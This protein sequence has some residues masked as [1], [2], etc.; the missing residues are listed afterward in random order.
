MGRKFL[1]IFII[2]FLILLL[3]LV[4]FLLK[5]DGTEV[6]KPSLNKSLCDFIINENLGK[7]CQ[8]LISKEANICEDVGKYNTLCFEWIL[9]SIKLSEDYCNRIKNNYGKIVCFRNLVVQE[10]DLDL[11][12]ENDDCFIQRLKIASLTSNE[13]ICNF[14]S[15]DDF[16]KNL[17]L[18]ETSNNRNYC[19]EISDD[20]MKKSCLS[21]FPEGLTD[22]EVENTREKCL[23][24]LAFQKKDPK[25]CEL[26]KSPSGRIECVL[27]IK[28][29]LNICMEKTSDMKDICIIYYLRN[30]LK[31]KSGR[32][33]EI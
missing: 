16:Y 6:L 26:I 22:C 27:N 31:I 13:E 8:A 32:F 29:D 3:S 11:C 9:G 17:C 25:I 15:G 30:E 18:A 2:F 10:R 12:M 19:K 5:K 24:E 14:F 28:N 7:S 33:D 1:L 4:F 23:Y 20:F 21:Y